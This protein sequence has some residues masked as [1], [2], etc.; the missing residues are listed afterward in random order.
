MERVKRMTRA[1][2]SLAAVMGMLIFAGCGDL[3]GNG[4]AVAQSSSPPAPAPPAPEDQNRKI[5]PSPLAPSRPPQVASPVGLSEE[6]QQPAGQPATGQPSGATLTTAPSAPAS[7]GGFLQSLFGSAPATNTP[8]SNTPASNT[9]APG[10]PAH[11]VP[12]RGH[13]RHPG[14]AASTDRPA[15]SSTEGP[16]EIK[17]FSPAVF[18]VNKRTVRLEISYR[19]D[20]GK[21]VPTNW[22]TVVL[23]GQEG[24]PDAETQQG[25]LKLEGTALQESGKL[26]GPLK[27]KAGSS[28]FT[29]QIM[30][31]TSK[32]DKG[33]PVSATVPVF[34]PGENGATLRPVEVGVGVKGKDYGA[35]LITT[36]VSAYFAAKE[37]I[38]IKIKLPHAL[39]SFKSVNNRNPNSQEEFDE[40]IIKDNGIE[41]PELPAGES[42]VYDPQSGELKILLKE[43]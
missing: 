18:R 30:E 13:S 43:K 10:G 16:T 31:G 4:T 2:V 7:G 12:P 39:Q 6:A 42:Y 23:R 21:P 27:V 26:Q 15:D 17:L 8:A 11:M 35:G 5:I 41:L 1:F 14:T 36:P 22:Y 40:K 20:K 32:E 33:H 29:L 38:A 19:F 3:P 34:L 37:S 25:E 24:T 9:R 28:A